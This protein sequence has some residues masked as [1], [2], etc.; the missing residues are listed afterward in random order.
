MRRMIVGILLVAAAGCGGGGSQQ[1]G[2]APRPVRG[3]ANLITEAE[4]NAGNYQHALEIIQNLR[5][6]MLIARGTSA[7]TSGANTTSVPVVIY[8]DDVRMNDQ[9]GLQN[10][11]AGQV[12]EIRFI[13]AR[14]A[15]TRWGTNH[16]SG[17]ILVTTKK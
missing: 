4:I 8:V 7:V 17:A 14:D 6:A 13:N 2:S 15:T 11:P 16:G 10:I 5:P 3:P 12:R 9:S 1:A